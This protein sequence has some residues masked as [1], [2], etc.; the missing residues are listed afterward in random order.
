MEAIRK[1]HMSDDELI[2]SREIADMLDLRVT[3]AVQLVDLAKSQVKEI[4]WRLYEEDFDER[5][6]VFLQERI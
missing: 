1:T 5:V 3:Q 6:R 2:F 4:E